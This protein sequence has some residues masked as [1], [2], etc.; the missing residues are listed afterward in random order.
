MPKWLQG[1]LHVG[2]GQRAEGSS[3]HCVGTS[4]RPWWEGCTTVLPSQLQRASESHT[5]SHHELGTRL[6]AEQRPELSLLGSRSPNRGPQRARGNAL[7][8]FPVHSEQKVPCVSSEPTQAHAEQGCMQRRLFV[9]PSRQWDPRASI[10]SLLGDSSGRCSVVRQCPRAQSFLEGVGASGASVP[11]LCS[12]K[13]A[14]AILSTAV[15]GLQVGQGL[16][17]VYKVKCGF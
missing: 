15:R 3:G 4:S 11:S 10:L 7:S 1:S 6:F 2:E 16:W 5:A 14:R 17:F 9:A 12:L 13:R 8:D